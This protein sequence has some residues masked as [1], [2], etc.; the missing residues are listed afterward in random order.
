MSTQDR[1][2]LFFIATLGTNP[3]RAF[4]W[5]TRKISVGRAADNDL[6][7][8]DLELSRH[9]AVFTR[10]GG[11]ATV[12]NLSDTNGTFVNDNPVRS[13]GLTSGD[14][15]MR[16]VPWPKRLPKTDLRRRSIRSR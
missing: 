14:R 10:E 4:V 2:H 8:D 3:A 11:V 1:T 12:E 15:I 13:I 5:D 7:I 16:P 9:H 6:C